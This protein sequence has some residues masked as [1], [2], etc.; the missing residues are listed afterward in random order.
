M[1]GN[2]L[3]SQVFFANLAITVL[4]AAAIGALAAYESRQVYLAQKS[5]E[6]EAAARLAA[7][8]L[9]A[10][11][12][13]Y[14]SADEQARV[15]QSICNELKHAKGMRLTVIRAS[16]QVIADSDEDPRFMDNHAE[17]E[18][19]KQA[20]Q[21][22]LGEI[23]RFS[24]TLRRDLMYRAV[25]L[26]TGAA[27]PGVVR[28]SLALDSLADTLRDMYWE[29]TGLALLAVA[30]SAGASWYVVRWTIRPLEALRAGADRY[31]HGDLK[32]R[33]PLLGAA[34]I[35]MLARSM[36]IMAEQLDQR[37][38]TIIRQEHEHNA[39]LS[40]M[41]EGV[42]AVDERST[43][44]SLNEAGARILNLDAREARGRV[45]HEVIRKADLLQ[46]IG[47]ALAS[48]VPVD[49]SIEASASENRWLHGRATALH[50]AHG[51]RIGALIVLHDITRLRHLENV[52]RDFVAN[53][54]HELRT[55]ITSI[56][57]FVETLLHEQLDDR[58]QSLRFLAIILKQVNR[59]D[60]II[61]DLL[62]LSRVE[63]GSGEPRIPL[64]PL[65]LADV[66]CAAVEMCARAAA[67]KKRIAVEL[68]C[69]DD[70]MIRANAPLLEQ[71]VVN[72]LDNAIKYS[73]PD[74]TVRVTAA[75]E[76]DQAVIRVQDHGCGIA[77]KHLPRLFERFY[78]VD[79]A[80]SREL[81]GTGLGL[82]IV[83]HIVSAH[84]GTV[85]VEST[86]GRG[87]TFSIRL[88]LPAPEPA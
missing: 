75:V 25:P 68:D 87:S 34:E 24:A 82:S 74:A 32:H 18:E 80:R 15:A 72:L 19:V 31:A 63:G 11:E 45:A 14:S 52:R 69:C 43:I 81:G 29:I 42:L 84:R 73:P 62:M 39:V 79:K 76:G 35:R 58:D 47:D 61:E 17:R 10:A 78:R 12:Q 37:I 46:F 33:L 27:S 1:V 23:T 66:L 3:F 4:L 59:L 22:G 8:R 57:G 49:R 64:E 6:L 44:L 38:Q 40:S 2:R 54:S 70:L 21:E 9:A 53:V 7:A 36:N 16:G 26:E 51:Q 20:V 41:E 13:D 30:L 86:V 71:A 56:K 65:R 28:A 48:D 85:Q 5:G 83:K 77:S 50:D 55:P 60:A 88:P 67:D